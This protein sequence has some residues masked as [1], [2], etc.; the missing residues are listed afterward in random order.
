MFAQSMNIKENNRQLC[1]C[2]II[3]FGNEKN[4]YFK[5]SVQKEMRTRTS[6]VRKKNE[7]GRK[8]Q[9]RGNSAKTSRCIIIVV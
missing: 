2:C 9:E 1:Q 8:G 3:Y 6:K 5:P 4:D 7:R